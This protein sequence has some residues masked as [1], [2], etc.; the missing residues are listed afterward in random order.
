M[1]RVVTILVT[2]LGVLAVQ[3][4]ANAV[5]VVNARLDET[6]STGYGVHATWA[7]PD[8]LNVPCPSSSLD[9]N[10]ITFFVRGNSSGDYV[11]SGVNETVTKFSGTCVDS[12]LIYWAAFDAGSG[13][14]SQAYG[15]VTAGGHD[16]AVTKINGAWSMRVDGGSTFE[17][18]FNNGSNQIPSLSPLRVGVVCRRSSVGSNGDCNSSGETKPNSFTFKNPFGTWYDW[19][20]SHHAC[21]DFNQGARGKFV[22]DVKGDIGEN[23][24]ISGSVQTDCA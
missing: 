13:V 10:E 5:A 4:A 7:K 14:Q 8:S 9:Y 23:V 12:G 17:F 22:T 1:K 3:T 19:T 11:A 24:S 2:V 18:V 6:W 16:Y 20:G 15:S 21:A